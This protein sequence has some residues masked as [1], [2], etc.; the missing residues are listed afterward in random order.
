MKIKKILTTLV[1]ASVVLIAACKKDNFEEI[2]GVCPLVVATSPVAN[3]TAVSTG[4]VV[5][6]TFNERMDPATIN[7]ATF[8]LKGATRVEG[9]VTYDDLTKTMSFTPTV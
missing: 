7:K 9:T 3:A 4:K 1:I 5:T 6:V 8:T 2:V